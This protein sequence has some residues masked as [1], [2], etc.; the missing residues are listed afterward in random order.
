[1]SSLRAQFAAACGRKIWAAPTTDTWPHGGQNVAG[2]PIGPR[3]PRAPRNRT[4]TGLQKPSRGRGSD[5]Q[6]SRS[7]SDHL[8]DERAPAIAMPDATPMHSGRRVPA[9]R[10]TTDRG[11]CVHHNIRGPNGPQEAGRHAETKSKPP[12]PRAC[13]KNPLGPHGSGPHTSAAAASA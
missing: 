8:G 5:G 11:H 10:A 13:P 2:D 9:A 7:D 6:A 4:K 1:M 12:R 3:P